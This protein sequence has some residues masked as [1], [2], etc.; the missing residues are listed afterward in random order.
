MTRASRLPRGQHRHIASMRRD[1]GIALAAKRAPEG[2][3]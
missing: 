2:A 3:V 1:L